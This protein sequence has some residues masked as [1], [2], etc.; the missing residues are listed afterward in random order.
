MIDANTTVTLGFIAMLGGAIFGVYG[1][2]N[3]SIA[4]NERQL[5]KKEKEAKEQGMMIEK[6][7]NIEKSNQIII[8]KIQSTDN[9]LMN[10]EQRI[11]VLETKKTRTRK[12]TN[13]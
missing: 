5:A 13:E 6:L 7:T 12:T 8:G 2:V 3:N 4:K 1:L 9:V 11:S 10:H